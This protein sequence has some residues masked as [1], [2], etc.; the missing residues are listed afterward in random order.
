MDGCPIAFFGT[1]P[2]RLRI[3]LLRK[4]LLYGQSAGTDSAALV[5]EQPCDRAGSSSTITVQFRNV[6]TKSGDHMLVSFLTELHY[7]SLFRYIMQTCKKQSNA[8]REYEIRLRF[9]Q[10]AI[11][12][13][14]QPACGAWVLA[15]QP[16]K[17]RTLEMS[18]LRSK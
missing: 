13:H 10:P 8:M 17:M 14:S 16:R 7:H 6:A 12:N 3:V 15:R 1:V 5:A 2:G 18:K 11:T 4:R 9:V